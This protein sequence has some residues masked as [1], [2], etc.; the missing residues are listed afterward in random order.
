MLKKQKRKSNEQQSNEKYY[1]QIYSDF[2]T[3]NLEL[4]LGN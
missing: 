3:S 2:E 1:V 4:I